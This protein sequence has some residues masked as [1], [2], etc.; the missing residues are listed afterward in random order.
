[1][2]RFGVYHTEMESL[3]YGIIAESSYFIEIRTIQIKIE[4]EK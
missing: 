3:Y 1:M 4:T 2:A